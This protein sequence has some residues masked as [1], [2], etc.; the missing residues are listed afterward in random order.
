MSINPNDFYDLESEFSEEERM[1]R[2]TVARFV[3]EQA[4]PVIP[5]A[6]DEHRF[7]LS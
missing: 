7:P 6:F 5:E 1:V 3:D 4:L 2:D